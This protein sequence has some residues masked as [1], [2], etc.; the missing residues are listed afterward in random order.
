[1]EMKQTEKEFQHCP[2]CGKRLQRRRIKPSEPE[3]LVCSGC[4]FIFYLDPKVVACCIPER[5]GRIALLKRDIE[6]QKGRWV[7]PGGYVDRGEE[8]RAAAMR[9]TREE[10]GLD[11]RIR[12]LLGVYSYEG[13]LPVVIVYRG[14]HVSGRMIS[15]DETAEAGWFAPEEIPWDQLAFRSTAD[16]LRDFCKRKD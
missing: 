12:D 7:I 10:C 9:E 13:H 14:E 1:M 16:A 4:G 6:P 8:V 5:D 15:G 3:R 2:V 11:V